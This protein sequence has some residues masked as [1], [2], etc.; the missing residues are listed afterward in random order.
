MTINWHTIFTSFH[1]QDIIGAEEGA[2]QALEAQFP[3][4]HFPTEYIEF[5]KFCD[6]GITTM[7]DQREL[8]VL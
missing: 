1:Y 4:G 5:L 8:Q 2:I 7:T 3:N 6:T